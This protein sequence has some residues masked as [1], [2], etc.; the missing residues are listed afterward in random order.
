MSQCVF[1]KEFFK[2]IDDEFILGMVVVAVSSPEEVCVAGASSLVEDG[3]V[4]GGDEIV[5]RGG[6]SANG[7]RKD[8][9]LVVALPVAVG[10]CATAS[11][12]ERE[13]EGKGRSQI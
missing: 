13:R 2:E 5:V 7:G 9:I 6:G 8:E 4:D 10:R 3:E 11:C 1:V 12:L